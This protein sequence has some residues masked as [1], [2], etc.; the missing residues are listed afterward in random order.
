MKIPNF[1]QKK[2]A[3]IWYWV[4][5]RDNAEHV[6]KNDFYG[7]MSI[8]RVQNK[9]QALYDSDPN[10]LDPKEVSNVFSQVL[11]SMDSWKNVSLGSA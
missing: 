1:L 7:V 2:S 6:N 5:L 10:S 9:L 11:R 3:D 8:P 4:K